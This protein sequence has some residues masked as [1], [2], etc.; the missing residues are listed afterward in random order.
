MVKKEKELSAYSYLLS[1]AL[2]L[3]HNKLNLLLEEES[4]GGGGTSE[5]AGGSIS[6]SSRYLP[7]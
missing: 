4:G 7:S 1:L 6:F 3:I 2:A 5:D